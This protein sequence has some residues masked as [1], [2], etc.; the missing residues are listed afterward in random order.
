MR[1]AAAGAVLALCLG[2]PAMG[3]WGGYGYGRSWIP[4]GAKTAREV[5]QRGYETPA[6]TNAPGFEAD[7][8]TF[9]RVRYDSSGGGRGRQPWSIDLP[10]SDLNLSYRLQQMTAMRI[11]PN[12]RILRLT[13][14]DLSDYPFLYIVEPGRLY[15]SD[16]EAAT[17]RAYLLN[18]GFLWLD[19][20]WGD[21]EWMLMERQL[22]KVFP[23]RL[24]QEMPID[25]PLYQ[26]V[27]PIRAKT[28]VP[29]LGTGTRSQFTGI[30]WERSD[31][32]TVHHRAIF[33]DH[34]RLMV[35]ATHNTDNGDGWEWEGDNP[36][37]F[38]EFSE[39]TAYPLAINVLFY[40][41]TH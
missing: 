41:M 20:F 2:G 7:V 17:L 25:H 38:R 9:A 18:G 39:R 31:A 4:D 13:D 10:D 40:T 6:W 36:Y 29:D 34:G 3:Q 11:D 30:T 16:Q 15:L 27:Y 8:L 12:G 24:F 26:C 1:H 28:Q 35:F 32:K 33:D 37:Y 21:D 23:L 22:K 19:D 5:P 14:P